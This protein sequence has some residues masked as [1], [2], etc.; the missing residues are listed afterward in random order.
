M[1]DA[2]NRHNC[3]RPI[4]SSLAVDKHWLVFTSIDD[5]QYPLN[6][7]FS[8]ATKI[9]HRQIEVAQPNR[10]RLNPLGTSPTVIVTKI[11]YCFDAQPRKAL[12][13][14]GPWLC[15]TIQIFIDLVKIW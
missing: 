14:S 11:N 7:F 13:S 3:T 2:I 5:R 12:E 6:L 15:A 4:G 9:T 8:R 1:F 10:A